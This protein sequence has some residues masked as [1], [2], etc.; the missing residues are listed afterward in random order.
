MAAMYFLSY[1]LIATL[2]GGV[3]AWAQYERKKTEGTPMN[4]T[5][6]KAVSGLALAMYA[7]AGLTTLAYSTG[8][9]A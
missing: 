7:G 1:A 8:L 4:M 6:I 3:I 5:V 9:M 2:V